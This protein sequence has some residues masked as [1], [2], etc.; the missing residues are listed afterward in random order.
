ML[1]LSLTAIGLVTLSASNIIL[2][3][4]AH[5]ANIDN[6][7]D[8]DNSDSCN[9]LQITDG[10]QFFYMPDVCMSSKRGSNGTDISSHM[11]ECSQNG[12]EVTYHVWTDSTNCDKSS[13]SQVS[14]IY[15]KDSDGVTFNCDG[16]SDSTCYTNLN[17]YDLQG[18]CQ[19]SGL[20]DFNYEQ[21]AI[22]INTCVIYN[23]N[24]VALDLDSKNSKWYQINRH[25][26]SSSK[27]LNSL[28]QTKTHHIWNQLRNLGDSDRSA[29][30]S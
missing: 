22:V 14:L 10:N 30:L 25:K 23:P 4:F 2:R 28:N 20:S 11:F 1:R 3:V 6:K 9:Y 17:I 12:K 16:S 26:K 5:A 27:D 7:D 18:K 8:S 19:D 21:M 13:N 24:D 15:T 29:M